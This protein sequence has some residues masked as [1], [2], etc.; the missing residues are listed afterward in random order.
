MEAAQ[1][2]DDAGCGPEQRP[3]RSRQDEQHQSWLPPAGRV[4]PRKRATPVKFV[5]S[6]LSIS[7]KPICR[8]RSPNLFKIGNFRDDCV[9]CPQPKGARIKKNKK[10]LVV[11]QN[12]QDRLHQGTLLNLL[13]GD[14]RK[15]KRRFQ[16]TRPLPSKSR[17]GVQSSV[18]LRRPSGKIR[19]VYVLPQTGS[20]CTT[21]CFVK[22]S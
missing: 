1:S 12:Q 14:E 20:P 11:D 8:R 4:A 3:Q 13:S 5:I 17:S 9:P 19:K 15:E 6:G 2:L 22:S 16:Q 21:Y 10:S 18:A 7:I